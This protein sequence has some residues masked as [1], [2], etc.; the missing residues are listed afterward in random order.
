MKIEIV[1]FVKRDCHKRGCKGEAHNPIWNYTWFWSKNA[2]FTEKTHIKASNE[3]TLGPNQCSGF[4]PPLFILLLM[5]PLLHP[6]SYSSP[7]HWNYEK[8]K[9]HFWPGHRYL[10]GPTAPCIPFLHPLFPDSK[11]SRGPLHF[12]YP[13]CTPKMISL[14]CAYAFPKNELDPVLCVCF[15]KFFLWYSCRKERLY[16]SLL[17]QSLHR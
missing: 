15:L 7:Q 4:V 2:Y 8:K 5:H 6:L 12:E 13:S 10:A 3:V 1:Y 9:H 14:G 16:F 11:S 17:F